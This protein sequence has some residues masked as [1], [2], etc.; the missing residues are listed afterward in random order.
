MFKYLIVATLALPAPA[1]AQS[2]PSTRIYDPSGRSI[3]TTTTHGNTTDVY[4]ASGR[5]TGSAVTN[6][7]Q[8]IFYD[9]SGR[10][11]GSESVTAPFPSRPR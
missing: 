4:D 5:R 9:A 2:S 1:F 10:R 6:N 8:T 7:G 11:T 3:G